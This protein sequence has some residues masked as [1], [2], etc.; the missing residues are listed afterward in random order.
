MNPHQ[1]YPIETQP[2]RLH[3]PDG[4]L[5]ERVV[6][7]IYGGSDLRYPHSLDA[8]VSL[9][10]WSWPSLPS[11]R[12]PGSSGFPR[13]ADRSL[14]NLGRLHMFCTWQND[15][16]HAGSHPHPTCRLPEGRYCRQNDSECHPMYYLDPNSPVNCSCLSSP[17]QRNNHTHR[18]Q[19]CRK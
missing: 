16:T 6:P 8:L 12:N 7:Y 9:P 15:R 11:M 5:L 18:W 10:G 1:K 14:E 19:F 3:P 17:D 4:V 13:N 2:P